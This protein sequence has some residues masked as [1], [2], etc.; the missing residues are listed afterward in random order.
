MSDGF[1]RIEILSMLS[2]KP[3]GL[4]VRFFPFREVRRTLTKSPGSCGQVASSCIPKMLMAWTRVK[5]DMRTNEPTEREKRQVDDFARRKAKPRFCADE[6]FPELAISVLR[7]L[8]ADVLTVQA[9]HTRGH[10]DENHIAEA[11][12]LGRILITCDRDYFNERRF[13]LINCPAIVVCDFGSGTLSEIQQ[14]FRC[15]GAIFAVP[16]FFDKWCK[17]DVKRNLWTEHS[18]HLD[19]ST[20]TAK[21]RFLCWLLLGSWQGRALLDRDGS[22]RS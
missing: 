12:R 7:S 8:K 11:L 21:Y 4:S 17:I 9:N 2:K 16:Q 22:H 1:L 3:A 14:T 6:N 13:P 18:R 15:M 20:S 5:D 10:P 19:G